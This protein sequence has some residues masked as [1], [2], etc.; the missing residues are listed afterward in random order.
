MTFRSFAEKIK[1]NSNALLALTTLFTTETD[2]KELYQ[3]YLNSF[4]PEENPLY[5]TNTWH[6]CTTCRHFI[7]RFGNVVAIIEGKLFSIWDARNIPDPYHKVAEAMSAYVKSKPVS[8][9]FL[10]YEPTIGRIKDVKHLGGAPTN[11]ET[12]HHFHVTLPSRFVKSKEDLNKVKSTLAGQKQVFVRGLEELKPEA[13]D[14]L[15]SLIAEKSI[16]RGEEF[17]ANV[18]MFEQLQRL[19]TECPNK[20]LFIWSAVTDLT[21]ALTTLRNSVVGTFLIDVSGGLDLNVAI[22]K[23][24]SMMAPTNYKRP[25]GVFSQTQVNR[26][27]AEIDSLGLAPSLERRFATFEDAEKNIGSLLHYSTD[28]IRA[29]VNTDIFTHLNKKAEPSNQRLLVNATYIKHISVEHF[30]AEVLPKITSMEV[31]FESR[32]ENNLMSLIAPVNVDAPLLFKWPNNYCL[33]YKDNTADSIKQ[34]VKYKGGDVDGVLR[35]SIQW[36][37]EGNNQDDLDA[38]CKEPKPYFTHIY[39]PTKG[40]RHPSS[41]MLDVDIQNPGKYVAVENIAYN[42][43]NKMPFGTYVFSVEN[44]ANRCGEGGFKA[45]LEFDGQIYSYRY[46]KRMRSGESIDVVAVKYD[47]KGFSIVRSIDE[48]NASRHTVWNTQVNVFQPV[49]CMMLSPNYWESAI[50]NKHYMFIMND[51]V[52]DETPNGFF[53]EY[54]RQDLNVH[55]QVF[56]TLGTMMKVRDARLLGQKQ[57]SGLGFSSTQSNHVLVKVYGSVTNVLKVII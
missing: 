42:D 15:L 5:G 19:Y 22:D 39:Y 36:N 38:H 57:L 46:D 44:Y 30:I 16:Y 17:E 25:K 7:E 23:Y 53:N 35:F 8:N 47:E 3:V 14:V 56:E 12:F 52:N 32:L 24:E 41:G 33:A 1:S 13:F 51:C 11:I 27:K 29:E 43:K 4:K 6:D 55:R 9:V 45:E 18:R 48:T 40:K 37:D 34:L 31:L 20:D 49:S 28:L 10:H 21:P 54:L 26:A 50:G 2:K